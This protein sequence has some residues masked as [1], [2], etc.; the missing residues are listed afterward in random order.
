MLSAVFRHFYATEAEK[1]SHYFTPPVTIS[2][3]EMS[4]EEAEK[5]I[6]ILLVKNSI[7]QRAPAQNHS[8]S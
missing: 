5:V 8:I 6:L 7:C 4:N 1:L 2:R 3:N